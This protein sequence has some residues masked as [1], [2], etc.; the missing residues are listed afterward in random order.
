M[1]GGTAVGEQLVGESVRKARRLQRIPFANVGSVLGGRHPGLEPLGGRIHPA[2]AAQYPAPDCA[3]EDVRECSR[4]VIFAAECRGGRE[5]A[6]PDRPS[7]VPGDVVGIHAVAAQRRALE[8][9]MASALA[10]VRYLSA[11]SIAESGRLYIGVNV[12]W[13]RESLA[14][15]HLSKQQST[16]LPRA[17][18]KS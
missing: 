9:I 4:R 11:G 8:A 5:K 10:E 18:T 16:S 12:R 6:L 2:P 13:M 17:A 14:R 1:E 3:G 7:R 15:S